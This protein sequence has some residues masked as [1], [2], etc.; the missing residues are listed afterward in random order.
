MQ[1]P[2]AGPRYRGRGRVQVTNFLPLAHALRTKYPLK[3]CADQISLHISLAPRVVEV[4]GI[5][6]SDLLDRGIEGQRHIRR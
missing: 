3:D 1:M 4:G 6:P 5:D 2:I